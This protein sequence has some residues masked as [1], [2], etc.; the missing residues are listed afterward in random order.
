MKVFL[1]GDNHIGLRHTNYGA[2]AP[3]L[4]E[5]R[6]SAFSQ[7][8]ETANRENCALF[9][10]A[11]DL[12][13]RPSGISKK[14][15]KPLVEHLSE[16]HGVVAVLPGN[17]D[18]YNGETQVWKYFEDLI[19]ERDNILLMN[20]FRPYE[21]TIDGEKVVL[22]PAFCTAKHS[23]PNENNLGWIKNTEIID[24]G[25]YHIGVA[26]G[27]VEGESLDKEGRYCVMTREELTGIPVD[28]W[29][30]GHTHVPFPRNLTETFAPAGKIF[31]AGTHVQTDVSCNT[32]GQCFIFEIS[33]QKEVLAKKFVSGNLRFVRKTL[34]L[35]AGAMQD[36]VERELQ[37]LGD[38]SVVELILTG[39]VTS[40]EYEERHAVLDKLLERFLYG[41][42]QDSE[43]SELIT[44]ERIDA[45][46]PETSFSAGLLTA[47]LDEPKEAQLVYD[48]LSKLKEGKTK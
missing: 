46:F 26:H 9:V 25:A 17:H 28:L 4:I 15:M 39:A 41:T 29:L 19:S 7:M 6:T 16:F 34:N 27:A 23:A 3:E 48:L 44:K 35:T 11:G 24:D 21:Q 31:N 36:A 8:V 30:I 5:S 14:E 37:P 43:L 40:E 18:Y 32:E 22:Y 47:L 33:P 45:E 1:T 12:F 13:D 38:R 10:V 42:F 2:A 20:E